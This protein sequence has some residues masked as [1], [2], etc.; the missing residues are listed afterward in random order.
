MHTIPQILQPA[1]NLRHLTQQKENR[2]DV[3]GM[4]EREHDNGDNLHKA[5]GKSQA[6]SEYQME[7]KG[8]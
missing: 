1:I 6:I 7:E 2:I 3:S 8:L 4:L 5:P